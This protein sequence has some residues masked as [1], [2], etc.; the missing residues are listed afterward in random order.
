MQVFACRRLVVPL[1][2]AAGLVSAVAAAADPRPSWECLPRDTA[3][4]LRMPRPTGFLETMR[5]RTKFG[6]VALG[7][8]TLR[9]AWELAVEAWGGSDG[10]PGEVAELEERLAKQGLGRKDL[11]ALFAGDMGLGLVM[12]RRESLPPLMMALAWAEPGTESAERMVAAF[13]RMLEEAADGEAAPQ[14]VDVEMAG[15]PVTWVTRPILRADLGEVKVEGGLDPERMQELR[16]ELAER[17]KQA[18]KVTVGKVHLFLTRIGGRLIVGQTMPA[19]P[20][21]MRVGLVPAEGGLRVD[22]G[23]AARGDVDVDPDRLSEIGRAHV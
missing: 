13:H 21:N 8:D 7:G 19:T 20:A 5:T 14:R 17:A 4:M 18:P 6:A 2:L 10:E 3:V 1:C 23:A 16:K 12:H 9:R 11:E 15:H 22:V